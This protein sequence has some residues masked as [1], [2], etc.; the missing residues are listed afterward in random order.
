MLCQW[1]ENAPSSG[2]TKI[3]FEKLTHSCNQLPR[4]LR[5]NEEGTRRRGI[6]SLQH[7]LILK[8]K[9][10]PGRDGGT[11][12]KLAQMCQCCALVTIWRIVMSQTK[13]DSGRKKVPCAHCLKEVPLSEAKVAEAALR[14]YE[15]LTG[16]FMIRR[17][18][19]TMNVSSDRCGSV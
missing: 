8:I 10:V 17:L 11:V 19:S 12:R 13:E 6:A 18:P 7:Q 14:Q 15:L 16:G 4:S 5:S 2:M 1:Q 9:G 3:E